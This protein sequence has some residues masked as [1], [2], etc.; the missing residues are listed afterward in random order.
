ME[1]YEMAV[2]KAYPN[3]VLQVLGKLHR[4]IKTEGGGDDEAL[5]FYY[6]DPEAAWENAFKNIF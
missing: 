1:D 6:S 4:V 2:K 3:A 5:S